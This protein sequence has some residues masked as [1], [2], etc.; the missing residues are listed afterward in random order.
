MFNVELSTP[1]SAGRGVVALRGDLDVAHA[2]GVASRLTTA[3]TIYGP[4]VVV[5]MTG[6]EYIGAAGLGVLVRVL[7][8]AR[9]KGGDLPLAAPHGGVRKIL[10]ATGLIGVFSVYPSLGQAV[11]GTE[12]ARRLA[13]G[14]GGSGLR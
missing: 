2:P 1:E 3:V 6:L 13:A 12:E 14:R 7:K 11:R 5:D 9:A 4:W 10:A 8:W